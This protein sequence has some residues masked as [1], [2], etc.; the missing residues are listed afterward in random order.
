LSGITGFKKGKLKKAVTVD[1]SKPMIKEEKGYGILSLHSSHCVLHLRLTMYVFFVVFAVPVVAQEVEV[2][3]VVA[4]AACLQAVFHH[5]LKKVVTPLQVM[6][7]VV[8]HH[9]LRR[10]VY[11]LVVWV[12]L[13]R[14][15]HPHHVPVVLTLPLL[16]LVSASFTSASA[17]EFLTHRILSSFCVAVRTAP[18]NPG[19]PGRAPPPAAR[20]MIPPRK[21]GT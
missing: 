1:K 4:V 5:S 19:P 10:G 11:R 20:R 3:A 13:L 6:L 16:L 21:P 2:V 8:V 7:Q 12:V 17:C 15:L 18:P 9:R 14:V